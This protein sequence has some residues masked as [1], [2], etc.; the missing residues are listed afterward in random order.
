MLTRQRAV[1]LRGWKWAPRRGVVVPALARGAR[2][3]LTLLAAASATTSL[4]AGPLSCRRTLQHLGRRPRL[5]PYDQSLS[6]IHS[7]FFHCFIFLFVYILPYFFSGC[8]KNIRTR[9]GQQLNRSMDDEEHHIRWC[10]EKWEKGENTN[11]SYGSWLIPID[12]TL[13]VLLRLLAS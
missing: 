4:V 7:F 8:S 13:F 12:C 9:D 6:L 10:S 1:R 5:E 11:V 2:M 3:R